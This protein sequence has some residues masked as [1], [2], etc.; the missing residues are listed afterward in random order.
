MNLITRFALGSLALSLA[1]C[2]SVPTYLPPAGQAT[3]SARFTGP[4]HPSMCVDG[5]Q[6]RLKL[7][8]ENDQ[9]LAALPAGKRVR[10]NAFQYYGGYQTSASCSA[11]LSLTPEE[12]K[13][14]IINNGLD[15][16]RCYIAA[17][18]EDES[19]LTGVAIDP[20]GGP[21]QC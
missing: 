10:I 21:P 17:V 16:S 3:V 1:A 8:T 4:G 19:T 13:P 14:V 2:T 5:T 6:Y 9:L 18:R 15:G 12:G 20:T 7:F 11:A